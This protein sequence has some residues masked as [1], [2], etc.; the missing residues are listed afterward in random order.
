MNGVQFE[1]NDI[2]TKTTKIYIHHCKK[3]IDTIPG[4]YIALHLECI[5][6]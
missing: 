3:S 1:F 4:T 6:Y 5:M 2:I